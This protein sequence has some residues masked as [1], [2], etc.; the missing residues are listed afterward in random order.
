MARTLK[1]KTKPMTKVEE[2]IEEEEEFEESEPDEEEGEE[3][4]PAPRRGR[5]ARNGRQPARGSRQ[6]AQSRKTTRRNPPK[7]SNHT[8]REWNDVR[9]QGYLSKRGFEIKETGEGKLWA[10]FTLNV[11][12]GRGKMPLFVTVTTFDEKIAS[13]LSLLEDES[14]EGRLLV[15]GQWRMRKAE[16]GTYYQGVLADHVEVLEDTRE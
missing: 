2:E 13:D 1:P 6:Q 4:E 11:S 16:S 5:S 15:L 9:F 14:F 3:E 8:Y 10:N 12:Q 7:T